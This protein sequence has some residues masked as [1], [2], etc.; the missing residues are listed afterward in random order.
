M[1]I[2]NN[3]RHTPFQFTDFIYSLCAFIIIMI[4]LALVLKTESIYNYDTLEEDKVDDKNKSIPEIKK[5]F[6][7]E[8]HNDNNGDKKD[9]IRNTEW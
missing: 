1:T 9:T 5:G 2:I 6:N 7:V 4:L 3:I 8:E